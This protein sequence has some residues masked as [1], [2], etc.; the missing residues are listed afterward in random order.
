[1]TQALRL[2]RLEWEA[3]WEMTT[4]KRL[5]VTIQ[6]V[7]EA[8]GAAAGL[9]TAGADGVVAEMWRGS[10]ML[11]KIRLAQAF[12]EHF[13]HGRQRRPDSWSLLVLRLLE[14]EAGAVYL[15][16]YRR[17]ALSSV[18][19]KWFLRTVVVL[20]RRWQRQQ[21]PPRLLNT[22]GYCKGRTVSS[23]LF[24]VRDALFLARRWGRPLYVLQGGVLEFFVNL[25]HDLILQALE[26]MDT[27]KQSQAAIAREYFD[28][29]GVASIKDAKP[30]EIFPVSKA[31][32]TGGVETPLLSL[33]VLEA[34]LGGPLEKCKQNG[35]GFRFSNVADES[36]LLFNHLV[37]ADNLYFF[38]S[39]FEHAQFIAQLVTECL[40]RA[41]LRWTRKSLQMVVAMGTEDEGEELT[42]QCDAQ[43]SMVFN[44]LEATPSLGE[45][46]DREGTTEP[47]IDDQLR[48]GLW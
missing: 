48:K 29:E 39:T 24:S 1:M 31:C 14:K 40:G 46:V 26:A 5:E 13:Q 8:L 21:E 18:L 11:T 30:T 25:D 20:L 41:G 7:M 42:V 34:L 43:G 16:Q 36:E 35:L 3:D 19:C 44:R 2:G 45:M 23:I 10:S 9:K 4:G 12:R 22:W 27:P 6:A 37:W 32:R 47:T 17:V 33:D 15:S 38:V 28:L